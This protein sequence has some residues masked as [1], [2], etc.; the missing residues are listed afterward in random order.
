MEDSKQLLL[1]WESVDGGGKDTLILELT[2]LDKF[3]NIKMLNRSTISERVYAIKF[4]RDTVDGIPLQ[5]QTSYWEYYF[6]SH[7]NTKIILCNPRVE[8]LAK[9]C[10]EK[11]E[12]FCRN[13]TFEQL[14]DYLNKDRILFEAISKNVAYQYGFDLL[15]LNTENSIND[16]IKTIEDFIKC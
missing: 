15:E 4:N 9:R 3:K 7:Y 1:I 12:D 13:R 5:I 8:V 2:K 10:I 14:V 16:C 6:K 11:Q